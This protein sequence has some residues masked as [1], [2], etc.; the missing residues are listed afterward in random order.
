MSAS[1]YRAKMTA[2]DGQAAAAQ[3]NV[4]RGLQAK[5][6]AE[7]RQRLDE[8]AAATQKIGDEVAKLNPPQNAE[9]ANTQLAAGMHETARAIRVLSKSVAGLHTPQEAIAYIQHKPNNAKG[10][11][12][13]N[14]ALTRLKKLGYIRNNS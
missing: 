13:V 6:L 2:I 5:T 8:F 10:A 11:R 7:L 4:A 1:A 12:D 9:A 14:E 3:A